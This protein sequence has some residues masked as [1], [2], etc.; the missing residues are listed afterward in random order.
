M[1]HDALL[2]ALADLSLATRIAEGPGLLSSYE[3]T[4]H[5]RIIA[6]AT[7]AADEGGYQRCA[8]LLAK[9]DGPL[10]RRLEKLAE[11]LADNANEE[12]DQ[13]RIGRYY[14]SSSRFAGGSL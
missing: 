2:L 3:R 14:G 5:L 9:F 7:D 6:D 4:E 8:D 12:A 13:R 11:S 1:K 10:V